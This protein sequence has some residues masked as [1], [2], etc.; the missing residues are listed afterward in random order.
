MLQYFTKDFFNPLII[1]GR[2]TSSDDLEIYA[3]LDVLEVPS[4]R[5]RALVRI[6]SW[7]NVNSL[8]SVEFPVDLV[9]CNVFKSSFI[10]I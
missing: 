6:Y 7:D 1:T 2:L 8:V 5:F 10:S 3:I 4:E 9:S